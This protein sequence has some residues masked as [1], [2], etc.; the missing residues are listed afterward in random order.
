MVPKAACYRRSL[1]EVIICSGTTAKFEFRLFI[2]KQIVDAIYYLHKNK[3]YHGA[4]R[5]ENFF[6]YENDV[7]K[8]CNFRSIDSRTANITWKRNKEDGMV[9]D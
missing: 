7:V 1:K 4:I 5:P 8:L 2:M 6:L 3:Y 9:D